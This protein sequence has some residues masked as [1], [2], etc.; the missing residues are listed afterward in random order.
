VIFGRA[1]TAARR[2][3]RSM[4]VRNYRL[5]MTGQVISMIGTWMQSVAQAW[6]VLKLGQSGTALGLVAAAQ[7]LPVLVLSPWGGLLADRFDKRNILLATQAGLGVLA[8]LLGVLTVTHSVRLWMVYCVAAGFGVMNAADN[9]ARQTFVLEMVGPEDVSNAV[10]LNSVTMNL[11]RIVGP[12]IAA[13]VIATLGTGVCFLVNGVSY[14]AVLIALVR[15]D[16]SLLH[17]VPAQERRKGQL[18]EGYAYVRRTPEVLSPLLLMA[19][20]GTLGYEFNVTLPL[21]AKYTFHGG[22]GTYGTITSAMGIGA[23]VG[24]LITASRKNPKGTYLPWVTVFFGVTL[25]AA[26][27]A[28]GIGVELVTIMFVGASSITFLA[29]ANT[30]LQLRAAPEMRGRVMSLW[31]M[32][33]LGSTPIGGPIVGYIGQHL[34]A[35]YGLVL[36]GVASVAAGLVAFTTVVGARRRRPSTGAERVE[37]AL[38]TDESVEAGVR[39]T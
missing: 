28:P 16:G 31:S 9:P 22:A 5:Y 13:V 7:F 20:V 26:A 23:V 27:L 21:I 6:L 18:R 1:A 14:V 34:G 17:R 2:T 25:V 32:A 12:A 35:R 37:V 30:T 15:M 33:F 10:T 39:L 8:V 19:V 36:G 38:A 4:S 11:A 29:V 24:G 3:F